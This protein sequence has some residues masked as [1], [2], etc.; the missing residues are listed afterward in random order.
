MP[1][2]NGSGAM[3]VVGRT[4]VQ[5]QGSGEGP[6]IAQVQL[7]GQ[8]VVTSSQWPASAII[9]MIVVGFFSL[10]INGIKITGCHY[11]DKRI[12]VNNSFYSMC[13]SLVFTHFCAQTVLIWPT[14]AF[15]G[16]FGVRDGV[17]KPIF[18]YHHNKN[19]ARIINGFYI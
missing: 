10:S 17:V 8:L 1:L 6:L 19:W 12:M 9:E 14:G 4:T 5:G 3:A 11:V 15:Y 2:W 7:E 18:C 16:S 13:Y